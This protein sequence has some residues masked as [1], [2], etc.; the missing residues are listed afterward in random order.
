MELFCKLY[1]RN[2]PLVRLLGLPNFAFYFNYELE[3]E[4]DLNKK[5]KKGKEEK[6]KKENKKENKKGEKKDKK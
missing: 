1:L 5:S 4:P 6:G 2:L 3:P